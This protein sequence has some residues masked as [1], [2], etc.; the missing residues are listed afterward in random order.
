MP[1]SGQKSGADENFMARAHRLALGG[2]NTTHP[3]PRV[4][5]VLVRDGEVVG[6][7]GHQ[8]AGEDHAEII[9]LRHAGK[10]AAGAT[11]YLTLEPCIHHGRTPPCARE[12]I[13]A[14]IARAVVA[15][16]DPNPSVKS[17]GI[18]ELQH[19]GISVRVGVGGNRARELNRGFCKRMTKG[20]P[21]VT[22]KMAAS[23]DGKT[24]MASGESRWITCEAARRDVH[25]MR[26]ACSAILTG[27]GTVLRD[28]PAMT[29]RPDGGAN[30]EDARQPLRVILDGNLSTPPQAKILRPPGN[31]LVI[32][33]AGNDRDAELLRADNV[34]VITCRARAGRIDLR[35]VME[36]LAAREINELLVEAGPRLAGSM[37]QLQLVD[38]IVLYVAPALLGADASGM[39]GIDGLETLADARALT[40][41]SFRDVRRV[42]ADLRIT[43]EVAPRDSLGE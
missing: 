26:A 32:T 38:E 42:G 23:L 5:C 8:Y 41:I 20:R 34:E 33:T 27:A 19:A 1:E 3:N 15:M 2:V 16:E 37:L 14:G 22:L 10:R 6:E 17:G 25:R 29:A 28:D 21:W 39:F 31:A 18:A 35:Q 9:A 11:A 43:L 24:A 7:G 13:K 36:E 12:L 40:G 30:A 4:G